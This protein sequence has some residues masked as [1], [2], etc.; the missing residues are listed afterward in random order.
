MLGIQQIDRGIIYHMT[1]VAV[2]FGTLGKRIK[3]AREGKELTGKELARLVGV[4]A[5]MITKVEK[6]Q[7]HPSVDLLVN[8]AEA[9]DVSLDWLIP[10]RG[11]DDPRQHRA[12]RDES[13][14]YSP[15]ADEAAKIIDALPLEY[16]H[17]CVRAVR[18]IQEHHL[19]RDKQD[20]TMTGLL[21]LIEQSRGAEFRARVTRELGLEASSA[22]YT[23]ACA[24]LCF[25]GDLS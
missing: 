4:S 15:E 20:Q 16:R 2:F 22:H 9:L 10:G 5:S 12:E 24:A 17:C 13:V 8:I 3:L 18:K 19:E 23:G 14:Y 6:N 7:K 11:V 21:D 1:D 25:F